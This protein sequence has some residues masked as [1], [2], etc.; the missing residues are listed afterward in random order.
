MIASP[1]LGTPLKGRALNIF[2][3]YINDVLLINGRLGDA[4]N[5]NLA[6]LNISNS[7]N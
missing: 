7:S 6:R 1:C 2:M 5:G 3:F 4:Q